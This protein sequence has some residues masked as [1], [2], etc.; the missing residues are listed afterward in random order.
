[1]AGGRRLYCGREAVLKLDA[2]DLRNGK[3]GRIVGGRLPG[4]VTITRAESQPG[5]GDALH[6]ATTS[7]QILP[8]RIWTP[9][10]VR[11]QL[12]DST[13]TGRDLTV[14]LIQEP[15]G[16][17]TG[18]SRVG[19][20]ASGV[21]SVEL[22]EVN[23][24]HVRLP[25][26]AGAPE[27]RQGPPG[28]NLQPTASD[29]EVTCNGPLRL[30]LVNHVATIEDR[31]DLIQ[32]YPDGSSDRLSCTRLSAYFSSRSSSSAAG[33]EPTAAP[34]TAARGPSRGAA[35]DWQVEKIVAVGDPVTLRSPGRYGNARCERFEYDLL[36]QQ[37]RMEGQSN[38]WLQHE[39]GELETRS[40]RYQMGEGHEIGRL[41]AAGPGWFRGSL[42]KGANQGMEAVWTGQLLLRPDRGEHL[43][44]LV[45]P[46]IPAGSP[47][48]P[49][50]EPGCWIRSAELGRIQADQVHVW[51]QPTGRQPAEASSPV[52]PAAGATGSQLGLRPNRLLAEGLVQFD[53]SRLQGSTRR[54]EVWIDQ[55]NSLSAAQ[56]A[57]AAPR[58]PLPPL[59]TLS[60]LSPLHSLSPRPLP[61]RR[62]CGV[63]GYG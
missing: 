45:G 42:V 1:M 56:P 28:P 2:L 20:L 10:E 8:D 16:G 61:R 30:D 62:T 63:T 55:A 43:L 7:A 38:V 46:A 4:P 47:S 29:V 52:V 34:A 24:I 58:L 9:H 48:Q 18:S 39:Q 14:L 60:P 26:P 21:R 13:I 36:A 22:A 27:V 59:P 23:R 33:A 49:S 32:L 40:L 44:S 25:P 31:V 35:R 3:I 54:L 57:P 19:S 53:S 37:L 5:A 50:A 41:W 15:A 11:M 51:L 17:K 6:V 12:G